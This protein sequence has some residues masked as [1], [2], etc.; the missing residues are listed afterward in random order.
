MLKVESYHIPEQRNQLNNSWFNFDT[1]K[2][3]KPCLGLEEDKPHRINNDSIL[4]NNQYNI[5][6]L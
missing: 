5:D 4:P 3:L 2:V 6:L 1:I